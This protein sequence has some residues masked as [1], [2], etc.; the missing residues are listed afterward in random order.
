MGQDG[1]LPSGF[2]GAPSKNV[3]DALGEVDELLEC[4]NNRLSVENLA[5]T[6]RYDEGTLNIAF[7][8]H[9]PITSFETEYLCTVFQRELDVSGPDEKRGKDN[10]LV[11]PRDIHSNLNSDVGVCGTNG[12]EQTMFVQDVHLMDAPEVVYPS[13]VRL[14]AFNDFDCGGRSASDFIRTEGFLA[15]TYWEIGFINGGFT[16]ASIRDNESNSQEVQR[17]PKVMNNVANHPTPAIGN[18]RLYSDAVD[19][20]SRFRVL[21]HDEGVGLTLKKG[22][23]LGFKI[24][25]VL[26][27]PVDLYPDTEKRIIAHA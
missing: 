20:V 16:G 18:G 26:I 9:R 11:L 15:G 8:W 12:Y 1:V 22:G 4:W 7:L 21:L 13:L 23:D 5:L 14:K 10:L 17:G 6:K 19:L 25:K 2:E 24:L 3:D 27:G